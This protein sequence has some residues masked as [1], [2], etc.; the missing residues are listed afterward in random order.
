[1]CSGKLVTKIKLIK[2]FYLY[3]FHLGYNSTLKEKKQ[4]VPDIPQ[5][6]LRKM[7][8]NLETVNDTHKKF[9]EELSA[10][11]SQEDAQFG[12]LFVTYVCR[13]IIVIYFF[14]NPVP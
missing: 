10:L 8:S 6:I 4:G 9:L 3:A 11:L 14:T 12:P 13:L 5:P 7:F 2:A 1:M